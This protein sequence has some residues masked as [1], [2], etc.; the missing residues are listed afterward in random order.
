[1]TLNDL[2]DRLTDL[3]DFQEIDGDTEVRLMTQP[4]WPFEWSIDGVVYDDEIDEDEDGEEKDEDENV[5]AIYILEG[6]QLGYGRR[7]AWD[8]DR[9]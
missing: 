4:N 8:W 9:G 1:M 6:Q 7:K 2:I 3:R 5:K